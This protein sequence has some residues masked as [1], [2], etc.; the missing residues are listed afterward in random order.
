[1]NALVIEA[2]RNS[3]SARD[4]PLRLDVLDAGALHVHEP[5]VPHDAPDHAGDVRVEAVGLH[6]AIDLGEYSG[7]L[8]G[9]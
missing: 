7:V 9:G 3:V 2:M 1:M 4:R 6:P 5:A 8:G